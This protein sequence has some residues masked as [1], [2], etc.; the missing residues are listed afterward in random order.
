M[1]CGDKEG[2]A[3][4]SLLGPEKPSLEKLTAE[5]RDPQRKLAQREESALRAAT[6]APEDTSLSKELG[7]LFFERNFELLAGLKK[8]LKGPKL[9]SPCLRMNAADCLSEGEGASSGA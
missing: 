7:A 6:L 3:S 5:A 2:H 4:A 9:E 8:P 1:R